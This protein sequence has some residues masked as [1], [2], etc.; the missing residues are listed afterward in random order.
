MFV[1]YAGDIVIPVGDRHKHWKTYK[2]E[3]NIDIKGDY[4]LYFSN[5]EPNTQI[6]FNLN[7]VEY[8]QIIQDNQPFPM[9]LSAGMLTSFLLILA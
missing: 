3:K 1:R 7:L 4:H 5:C 2:F 9:Y 6:N 8:N